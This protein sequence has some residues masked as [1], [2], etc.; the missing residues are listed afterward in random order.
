MDSSVHHKLCCCKY[1]SSRGQEKIVENMNEQLTQI[2]LEYYGLRRR[3]HI[4]I[5]NE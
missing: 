1:L 4:D 2:K 5:V 3:V